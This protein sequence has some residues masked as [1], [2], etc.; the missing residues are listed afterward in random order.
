MVKIKVKKLHDDAVIPK[1]MNDSDACADV[2]A[3]SIEFKNDKVIY[4]IG[5]AVE[6][7]KGYC[8]KIYP[9]S[10]INKTSLRLCN[11]VGIIDSGYRNE[12]KLVFDVIG[13][14]LSDLYADEKM[15]L[16]FKW[17]REQDKLQ[18]RVFKTNASRA[19][20]D[21][22]FENYKN[23]SYDNFLSDLYATEQT[24]MYRVGERIGQAMIEKLIPTEYIEVAELNLSNDRGGGFGSTGK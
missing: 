21:V 13:E 19:A 23:Y 15:N 2:T 12:I 1:F 3:T 6:I 24:Y 11:D 20:V 18:K 10:S 5:L 4:G 8:M 22:L 7:P 17:E 16:F 14:K 9:R